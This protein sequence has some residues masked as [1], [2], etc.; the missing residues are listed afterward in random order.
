MGS[1]EAPP[2]LVRISV[3]DARRYQRCEP[4]LQRDFDPSPLSA[5]NSAPRRPP[6]EYA[7]VKEIAGAHEAS[8]DALCAVGHTCVVSGGWDISLRVWETIAWERTQ[9]LAGQEADSG[10]WQ[11]W[12]E[13]K[14]TAGGSGSVK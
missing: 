5:F 7:P 9:V 10:W 11:Q 4:R 14:A 1:A 12:E 3:A 2:R 8:V 13:A 6:C